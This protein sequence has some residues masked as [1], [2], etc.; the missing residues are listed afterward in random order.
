LYQE[1]L[2]TRRKNAHRWPPTRRGKESGTRFR[3]GVFQIQQCYK[4]C[5]GVGPWNWRAPLK[6]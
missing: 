6:G 1:L 5:K 2:S 4:G 3:K